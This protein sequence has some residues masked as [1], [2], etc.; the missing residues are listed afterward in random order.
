M[1]EAARNPS[2]HKAIKTLMQQHQD[3]KTLVFVDWI[4]QGEELAEELDLPFIYGETSHRKRE[5][6]YD[7]FR[8]GEI[9][10]L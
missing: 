2:K 1:I 3:S 5:E 6:I 10:S 7:R 9:Q 4:D 8:N